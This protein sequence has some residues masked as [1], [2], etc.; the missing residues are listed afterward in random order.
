MLV[1]L[2]VDITICLSIYRSITSR[3]V[4][5]QNT[6]RGCIVGH[7]KEYKLLQVVITHC[8][9]AFATNSTTLLPLDFPACH[10]CPLCCPSGLHLASPMLSRLKVHQPSAVPR[11][12]PTAHQS[13]YDL[14]RVTL[15]LLHAPTHFAAPAF[16]VCASLLDLGSWQFHCSQQ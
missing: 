10:T 7:K 5:Y 2:L 8:L 16:L 4:Y 3:I 13:P 11:E 14:S 9:G 6:E 1:C 15:F 12:A